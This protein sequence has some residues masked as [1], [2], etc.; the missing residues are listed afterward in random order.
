MVTGLLA[1]SL[2]FYLDFDSY[3]AAFTSFL[4]GFSGLLFEILRLNVAQVNS[5]F[6]RFAGNVLRERERHRVS[7]F[8]FYCFGVSFSFFFFSWEVSILSVLF[9]IFADPIA[10]LVG[11][12]FGSKPMIWGKTWQGSF[13]CFLIC[14][15]I[16]GVYFEYLELDHY[17]A[18]ALWSGFA[19]ATGELITLI[20]DNLS[21][22]LVSGFLIEQGMIFI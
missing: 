20:D 11:L 5:I 4:I 2:T 3:D 12:R 15:L 6:I 22:P 16:A 21:L 1:L 10:S 17:L 14:F 9:L 13:A 8:I 19:G 7:G 18:L